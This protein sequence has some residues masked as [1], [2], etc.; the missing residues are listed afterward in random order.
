MNVRIGN[1]PDSWGI[2][3]PSDAKQ[4]PWNRF[5]DEV[6]QAGYEGIELGPYGYLPKDL[7]V[8]ARGTRQA[9]LGS[10]FHSRNGPSRRPIGVA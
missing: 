9:R 7:N 8:P 6:V 10:V 2:S 5:L 4:P 3:F 1:T